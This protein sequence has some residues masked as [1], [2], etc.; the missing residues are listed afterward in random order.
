MASL[1]RILGALCLVFAA[2][3]V[4]VGI[5]VLVEGSDG[6]SPYQE[7]NDAGRLFAVGYF[8]GTFVIAVVLATIGTTAIVAAN[9]AS[10][11]ADNRYQPVPRPQPAYVAPTHAYGAASHPSPSPWPPASSPPTEPS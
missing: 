5:W 1:A 8:L 10:R 2:L 6:S 7:L 4:G 3:V 11:L 9:A